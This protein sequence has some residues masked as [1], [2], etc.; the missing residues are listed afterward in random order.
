MAVSLV[1]HG[2]AIPLEIIRERPTASIYPCTAGPCLYIS[3]F[4]PGG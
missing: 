3:K 1:F 4:G 2:A